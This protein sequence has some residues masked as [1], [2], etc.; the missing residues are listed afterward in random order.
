MMKTRKIKKIIT[1]VL[2]MTLL[3]LSSFVYADTSEAECSRIMNSTKWHA[4]IDI[5]ANRDYAIASTKIDVTENTNLLYCQVELRIVQKNTLTGEIL[6]MDK[7]I[8]AD[9]SVYGSIVIFADPGYTIVSAKSYH[10]VYYKGNTDS[11]EL[12]YEP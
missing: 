12:I 3:L 10:E 2:L 5:S 11:I 6:V 4:L 7:S 9:Y 8:V 1:A